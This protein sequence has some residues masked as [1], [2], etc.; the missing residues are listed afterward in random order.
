MHTS[1]CYVAIGLLMA[2]ASSSLAQSDA[3][4]ACPAAVRGGAS[5]GPDGSVFQYKGPSLM[6]RAVTG[7][8]YSGQMIGQTVK[9]LASGVH[10]TQPA[11]GQPMEHRDS[12][13]RVRTDSSMNPQ[14]LAG[15]SMPQINR[16]AEIDDPV[17]GYIYI[18]DDTRKI[19][20]RIVPCVRTAQPAAVVRRP[21]PRPAAPPAT[22]AVVGRIETTTED[23]GTQT[24]SGVT[25]TGRRQTT[26]FPPGTYL[27]QNN[28]RT[29]TRV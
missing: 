16:L 5:I 25:V 22:Q 19:A 6:P 3:A 26:T 27:G 4:A 17:A 9:T 20:H 23:L 8:P 12:A 13:G 24:M 2:A 29:V 11:L 28:D 14:P 1:S 7:A 21:I 10:L 18:L 15:H